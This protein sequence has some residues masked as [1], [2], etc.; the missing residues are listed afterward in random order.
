MEQQSNFWKSAMT[1]GLYLGIVLILYSVILYV[2]G[3][4][5]NPTLG[6]ISYVIMAAGVVYFQIQYRN[7][8]LGGYISYGKALGYGVAMMACAGVIQSLYTVIL[9]KY[10]DPTII[11]QIRVMQE[12]QMMAQG[13]SDQQIEQASSMMSMFQSPIIIAISGLFVFALVGLII[14]V[15]SSIFVKKADD[16][17]AFTS[18]MS[19]I[20]S[21]E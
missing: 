9:M 17:S 21:E 6:Y 19:D 10:I 5:L 13:L 14:S 4:N 8:E 3:Q 18:A 7:N 2:T 16:D 20:K 1:H 12:E 15:I 11:D